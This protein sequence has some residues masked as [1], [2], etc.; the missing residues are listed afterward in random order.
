MVTDNSQGN[1]S[2]SVSALRQ[3][4]SVKNES[5]GS[6]SSSSSTTFR[7]SV[8]SPVSTSVPAEYKVSNNQELI[9]Y[10]TRK[11]G[12]HKPLSDEDVAKLRRRQKAEGVV[13]GISDAMI[14]LSNMIGAV[15]Y[16]PVADG[17][18]ESMSAKARAR[19]D[20]EAAD[21]KAKDDEFF[22]YAMMLGKLRD[23]DRNRGLDI[24][25]TEQTL[26]RQN[27]EY[28][29]KLKEAD[30]KAEKLMAEAEA[31]KKRGDVH[32]AE[33]LLKEAQAVKARKEAS[34]VDD[35]QGS[36]VGRNNA[37]ATA[38]RAAAAKSGREDVYHWNGQEYYNAKDY[39]DAIVREAKELGVP[40]TQLEDENGSLQR[41]RKPRPINGIKADIM[42]KRDEAK[43][44]KPA[45]KNSK[46]T[47]KNN[48]GRSQSVNSQ[49]GNSQSGKSEGGN[50]QGGNIQ[51]DKKPVK[52]SNTK[53]LGL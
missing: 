50:I 45:A 3:S 43:Q 1:Y 25:K 10:L 36:I 49:G 21:R 23:A 18:K 40:V 31:A 53:K 30:A 15:N 16:A 7:T 33:R 37:A 17:S 38:S 22:N 52:G 35:V 2:E 39:E 4:P 11:I 6:S 34:W 42:R 51:G 26:A 28:A 20:K 32:E 9:N 19:F 24:W 44:N 27:N 48:S 41:V 12:E 14:A 5:E 47:T 13:N 8:S 46:A 29:L